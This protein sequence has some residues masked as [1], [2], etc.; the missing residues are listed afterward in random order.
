MS[1]RASVWRLQE[2]LWDKCPDQASHL[3]TNS[4]PNFEEMRNFFP[5]VRIGRRKCNGHKLHRR[6]GSAHGESTKTPTGQGTVLLE[7]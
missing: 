5:S 6:S 1:L 4:H 2:D 3:V 7:L